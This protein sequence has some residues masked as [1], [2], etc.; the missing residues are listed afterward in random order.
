MAGVELKVT[1]ELASVTASGERLQ[2]L[3]DG[4]VLRRAAIQEYEHGLTSEIFSDVW[5]IDTSPVRH[6]SQSLVR[7]GHVK[8]WVY[9]KL[10]VDRLAVVC[11]SFKFVLWDARPE[12][13]TYGMVNEIFL[14]ERTPGLLQIPTHVVHAVQNVGQSDAVFVNLPTAPYNHASPD[15]YRIDDPAVVPYR[16]DKGLIW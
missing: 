3:I 1:K 2:E 7:A 13:P 4:V 8:G 12:S 6:V 5:D 15:K 9:H 14:S 16:F 11:G 10:T